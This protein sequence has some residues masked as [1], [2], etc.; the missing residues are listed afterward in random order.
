MANGSVHRQ[1]LG[2]YIFS[3]VIHGFLCAV[4]YCVWVFLVCAQSPD[5]LLLF[6]TVVHLFL[7]FFL[8]ISHVC[9]SLQ[10]ALI[11]IHTQLMRVYGNICVNDIINVRSV[12][13]ETIE[14]DNKWYNGQLNKQS[15]DSKISHWSAV[16]MF[17]MIEVLRSQP[18]L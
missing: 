13:L 7:F 10:S 8:S 1:T 11:W 15:A 12:K 14:I 16:Y 4:L 17:M 5:L 2:N 9:I 3:Q 18:N 6:T